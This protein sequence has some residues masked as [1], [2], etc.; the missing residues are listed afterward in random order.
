[1]NFLGKDVGHQHGLAQFERARIVGHDDTGNTSLQRK[2]YAVNACP[3]D[4]IEAAVV[5]HPRLNVEEQ[6]AV[7]F[8]PARELLDIHF[9]TG[10]I[11]TGAQIGFVH[12]TGFAAGELHHR[13][14]VL[15]HIGAGSRGHNPRQRGFDMAQMFPALMP[16]GNGEPLD[17][18][19]V[20]RHTLSEIGIRVDEQRRAPKRDD[21]F[22]EAVMFKDLPGEPTA[23][24]N[25]W[26][27]LGGA[28]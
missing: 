28:L 24:G 12:E 6:I 19:R 16:R 23:R 25:I 11:A 5:F 26:Y 3:N 21:I 27:A 13:K 17:G 14:G 9:G 1:M 2:H 10:I 4:E 8:A 22:P 15:P 18:P 20:C 7:A